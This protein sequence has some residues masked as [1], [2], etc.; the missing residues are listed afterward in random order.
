MKSSSAPALRPA[1][2]VSRARTCLLINQ[3][4]TPGLGS[5]AGRRYLAGTGQLLL[6]VGGFG[7]A[8]FWFVRYFNN[9]YRSVAEQPALPSLG[10]VGWLGA[11]FFVASWLWSWVTSLS[12]VRE[13][14]VA[15]PAAPAPVPP[16]L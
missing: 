10:W 16:R 9:I 14:K 7:L 12:L 5:I 13:A 11:A 4:A 2:S 6:A 15:E 3:T 1:L 8:L